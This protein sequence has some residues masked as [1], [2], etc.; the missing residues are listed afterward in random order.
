M[1]T[2]RI[3]NEREQYVSDLRTH[4][5]ALRESEQRFA[6]EL[7]I[8]PNGPENAP[9]FTLV[10]V[11]VIYGPASEPKIERLVS[12]SAAP[13]V[14]DT[15]KHSSGV[16][17]TAGPLSWENT[18]FSFHCP[19]FHREALRSWLTNWLDVEEI[20]TEDEFGL[21]GVIHSMDATAD[22]SGNWRVVIDFGSAPVAAFDELLSILSNHQI[23]HCTLTVP[24]EATDAT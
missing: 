3:V 21:S 15:H 10:R 22:S 7:L 8:Q 20:R 6:A 14:V 17:V 5:C 2:E 18:C 9:P 19:G 11:D 24:D 16:E 4:V 23:R 12:R 1:L 13:I